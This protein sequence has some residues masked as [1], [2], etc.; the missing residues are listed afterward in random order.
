MQCGMNECSKALE[1]K[2]F[3]SPSGIRDHFKGEVAFAGRLKKRNRILSGRQADSIPV[4]ETNVQNCENIW[5]VPPL[6][7][8]RLPGTIYSVSGKGMEEE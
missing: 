1:P 6:S 2:Y 7:M 4:G 5:H 8:G 3:S